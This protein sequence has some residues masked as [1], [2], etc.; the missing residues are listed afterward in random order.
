MNA[1][2]PVVGGRIYRFARLDGVTYTGEAA[3]AVLLANQVAG[4]KRLVELGVAVKVNTVLVAGVNDSCV[5]EVGALCAKL[6]AVYHN[7][8]QHI[9]VAGSVFGNLPQVS[10]AHL[11]EVRKRCEAHL[12]QMYHCQ[13]CRADAMGKLTED[14]VR[15]VEEAEGRRAAEPALADPVIATLVVPR[16][17]GSGVRHEPVR[18]AVASRS[19]SVVDAH[20]GHAASFMVYETDG[21]VVRYLETREVERYCTGREAC[22]PDAKASRLARSIAAVED[23]AAV[24]ALRIGQAPADRLRARGIAPVGTCDAIEYQEAASL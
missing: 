15:A 9:P 12:P 2:D 11:D 4:I 19:G 18:I 17:D 6:G 23:C 3:G 16:A 22:D 21:T 7:V 1:V 5:E 20:F 13:Q 24:L 10:R 8:M 14:L